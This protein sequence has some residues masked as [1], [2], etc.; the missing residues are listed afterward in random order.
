MPHSAD[1]NRKLRLRLIG[2]AWLLLSSGIVLAQTDEPPLEPPTEETTDEAAADNGEADTDRRRIS[3]GDPGADYYLEADRVVGNI[4]PSIRTV[5]ALGNVKLVQGS[6]EITADELYYYDIEQIALL[7][8]DVR[9]YD[10]ERD[11]EL[12]GRYL[13]YHREERYCI[14]TE[15]PV[16]TLG[17]RSGGDVVIVGR[18]MEY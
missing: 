3:L 15:R 1:T 11:A 10:S 9:V 14:V 18:V 2:L 8:G 12:T 17:G 6:T 4:D 5:R 7:K 13:E 16:L